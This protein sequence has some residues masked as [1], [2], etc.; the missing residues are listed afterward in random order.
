M[1]VTTID[2]AAVEAERR[3]SPNFLQVRGITKGERSMRKWHLSIAM[4]S[5]H[6]KSFSCTCA[7][8]SW[9]IRS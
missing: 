7:V 6:L 8:D 2:A 1:L 4:V 3:A 9:S 5:R